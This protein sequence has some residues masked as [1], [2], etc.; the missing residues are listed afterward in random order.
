[1]S[2]VR[3]L[4]PYDDRVAAELAEGYVVGTCAGDC[5]IG[6]GASIT[7]VFR[8]LGEQRWTDGHGQAIVVNVEDFDLDEA[9]LR[10]W[11]TGVE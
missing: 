8:R 5:V 10:N 9:A 1:M 4:G 7:G 11:A 2:V 6:Q 3:L